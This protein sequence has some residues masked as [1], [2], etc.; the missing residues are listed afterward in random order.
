M[1]EN[2]GLRPDFGDFKPRVRGIIPGGGREKSSQAATGDKAQ[3]GL[4]GDTK[5][6]IFKTL[7]A[8]F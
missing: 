1:A 3:K 5:I 6:V 4:S 8:F 7:P 2:L